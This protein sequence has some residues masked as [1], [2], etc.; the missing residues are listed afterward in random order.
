MAKLLKIH[1]QESWTFGT[2]EVEA[3]VTRTGGHLGPVR[4]R[5]G[6]RW[7]EPFDLAPWAGDKPTTEM[8]PVLRVLRGDFFC[9]P[10]GGNENPYGSEKFPGHGETSNSVWKFESAA[11]GR[12]DLSME[13]T[14][15]K[16]RVD[17]TIALLPGQSA[18]YSRHLIS[19]M[20]GPMAF[21]HHAI[22]KLPAPN[23]GRLSM[24]KFVYGQ[25]F[26]GV[27][28]EPAKG[29]YSILKPGAKFSSLRRV[30]RVDGKLADLSIYP[31]RE[32][33]EDVVLMGSDVKLPFAW[34]AMTI[35]SEGY[36]WF[37]LKDPRVLAS[38]V[39]WMSNGGR[40]YAPWN[41]RHRHAIGLEEVTANFQYGLA[42][43][44]KPNPLNRAGI[45]TCVRMDPAKP[46]AVNYIM[47]VSAIP[48]GFDI[49][50]TIRPS[51]DGRSVILTSE[52]RKTVTSPI[53]L[54]FLSRGTVD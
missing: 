12:L 38:T 3:A 25:V 17:K 27:F 43:S 16:G 4:F 37:A 26:P 15:R 8:P 49:V 18:L 48:K 22:L 24:S 35:P 44:A 53:N 46:F 34:T 52:S 7:V 21:G 1:G 29:G 19:G 6:D 5:L 2:A 45:A 40:H 13:T 23:T 32:G 39:F 50:K 54:S 11:P 51:A 9:M 28:E 47:A 10:F 36:V 14:I 20:K 30:P 41:G 42:E 31:S 33:Y